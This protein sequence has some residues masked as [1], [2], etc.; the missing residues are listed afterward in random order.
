MK[1]KYMLRGLGIG[2]L[3]TAAIMGAYTRNAVADARVAVMK[4]YGFGEE[5]TLVENEDES[6]DENLLAEN[7]S[8]TEPVILRDEEIE[9]QIYS[10]L[11]EALQNEK[12]DKSEVENES[13]SV[14][15][16]AAESVAESIAESENAAENV[17]E[18]Q[19][20]DDNNS[21]E[22]G[23]E[24]SQAEAL[25]EHMGAPIEIE[26]SKGDDSGTVARKLYN[27]GAVESAAEYDAFLI[28][29]GYDKKINT[30]VKVIYQDDSWQEIAE[31]ITK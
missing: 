3:I 12:S 15:E 6:V 2:V 11:D 24:Q 26:I 9:S 10:V 20:V 7:E 23:N 5:P 18:S 8:T 14:T 1:L 27:I 13:E 21:A 30:G 22:A 19:A 28:Q 17:A 16:S 31:K 29:H 25:E 4:E